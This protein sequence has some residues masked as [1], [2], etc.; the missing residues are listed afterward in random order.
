[1]LHEIV[2]HMPGQVQ[3][4]G[5]QSSKRAV[6]ML[7][8]RLQWPNGM[9]GTLLI[10]LVHCSTGEIDLL[11]HPS[12]RAIWWMDDTLGPLGHFEWVPRW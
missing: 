11:I 6:V 3:R 10:V 8:T 2:V 4:V 1:M 5:E 12:Y 7:L 9:R